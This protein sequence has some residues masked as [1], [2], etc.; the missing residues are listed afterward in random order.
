M[1]EK[2]YTIPVTDVFS[3]DCECPL[4]LLEERLENEELEYYLGPAHMEPDHRLAT[5]EKGFCKRHFG[6][7]YHKQ[8]NTLGLA[9]IIETHLEKLSRD[10]KQKVKATG[11][12]ASGTNPSKF[13]EL[14]KLLKNR[15]EAEAAASASALSSW[16]KSVNKSCAICDKL[17]YTMNRYT[18]VILHLWCTEPEFRSIFNS[19]KGFCMPHL[20]LLLEGADKYLNSNQVG[21]FLDDLFNMQMESLGSLR[22][23]ITWFTKKFDYR[24]KDASWKNSKDAVPRSIRKLSGYFRE[25]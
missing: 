12:K 19:K 21:E 22:E 5:N 13:K 25:R 9:L 10:L 14:F 2:I 18:D 7:L 3:V 24:N 15:R 23:D 11:M 4:C 16:V 6:M 8:E 17:T 1:K 20:A